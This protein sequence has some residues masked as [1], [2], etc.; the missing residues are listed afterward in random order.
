MSVI[1]TTPVGRLVGGHPL[2]VN[3]VTDDRTKLPK[4][5]ADGVTPRTDSYVGIAIQKGAETHWNQTPWGQLITQEA[6][7]GWPNG[8]FNALTFAWKI[9]D[10]DSRP[11]WISGMAVREPDTILGYPWIVNQAM[12]STMNIGI[13]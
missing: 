1:I 8:E 13:I 10:G 4:M 2:K 6:A 9:V 11:L 3:A 12:D 7:S 5:Q